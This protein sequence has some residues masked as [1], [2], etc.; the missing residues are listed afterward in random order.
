MRIY[1]I[2]MMFIIGAA[3]GSFLCCQARRLRRKT[4]KKSSLGSRSVCLKCQKQL[5]WFDNIPLL[6]WILLRGHCRYCNTKIGLAEF[7]SELFGGIIFVGLAFILK[8]TAD[9]TTFT[10]PAAPATPTPFTIPIFIFTI[11]LILSLGFLAI[12]DALYQELPSLC[13]IFSI[14]CAIIISILKIWSFILIDSFSWSQILNLL[15]SIIILAGTYLALYLVSKGKW[16][17]DGDWLLCLA[18]AFAL[19]DSF[20]SLCVLFFANFLG[21]VVMLPILSINKKSRKNLKTAKIP[22]GPFLVAGFLLALFLSP[23]LLQ[24]I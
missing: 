19:G 24:L 3:L 14:I 15:G 20:L 4:E 7:L 17:G 10:L 9:G 6:S 18:L 5:R 1:F 12:Y 8:F 2:V 23:L 21:C 22:F 16:I 13:L 11:I